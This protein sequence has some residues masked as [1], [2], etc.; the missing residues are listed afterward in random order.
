MGLKKAGV[1]N[2]SPDTTLISPSILS[3][4]YGILKQQ[5]EE[6]QAAGAELIH[7]DVM[8]GHFVP[9]FAIGTDLIKSLRSYSKACFDAHLMIAEPER[10]IENFVEAGC[11][12]ITIHAEVQTDISKVLQEIRSSGCSAG[13]CLKPGTAAEAVTP[14]LDDLDL[15]LI[16][17]VEPGFSGQAFREDMLDKIGKIKEICEGRDIH[18]EVDGGVDVKTGRLCAQAGANV[19]AAASAVFKS[20]NG[21]SKAI[22]DLRQAAE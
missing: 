21:I 9:N 15:I 6:C 5:L 18:I 16:M 13:L 19:L 20:D 11:D 3:A 12:H 1:Q 22:A 14:F 17:T 8:D 4:D 7:I 10:Y 2:F